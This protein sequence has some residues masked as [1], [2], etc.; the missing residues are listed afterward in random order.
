MKNILSISLIALLALGF[1]ACK[2]NSPSVVDKNSLGVSPIVTTPTAPVVVDPLAPVGTLPAD[3]T[4]KVVLEE[5]TG[6][7]CGWCP[8]G[9]KIMED[10]IAANPGKVVGIAVHDGDPM[11]IPSFNAWIKGLTGVWLS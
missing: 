2:K 8:E 9:A 6:E 7:W 3:Y 1:S 4:K 11:E 5:F 10:N